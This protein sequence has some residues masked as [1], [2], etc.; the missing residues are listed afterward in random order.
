M[1]LL[2]KLKR[3]SHSYLTVLVILGLYS[4]IANADTGIKTAMVISK[5]VPESIVLEGRVEAINHASI[6]AQVTGNINALQVQAGDEVTVGQGLLTIDSAIADQSSASAQAQAQQAQ[7]QLDLAQAQFKRQANLYKQNFIS[8]AAYDQAA[9]E[10]KTTTANAKASLAQARAANYS[11]DF[12]T[13]TAP[14]N[15]VI[16]SLTANVGDLA[17]PGR[18]LATMYDPGAL[19]IKVMLPQ[20]YISHI[21]T[22]AQII[23]AESDQELPKILPYQLI[24]NIN[25]SQ[26]LELRIN[27]PTTVRLIPGSPVKIRL[28][29]DSSHNILLIPNQAVVDHGGIP[30]VYVQNQ[31]NSYGLRKV[32]TGTHL[33]SD[34]EILAGLF[35]G[36]KII[37]NPQALISGQPNE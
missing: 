18:A 3:R 23:W 29:L 2:N 21:S 14:F 8:K 10:L 5:T 30:N 28:E 4:G 20:S 22:N 24:P 1:K 26:N 7:A 32:K 12:Y 35:A 33:A 16:S 17:T 11:N 31:D 19:R 9:A 37:R 27:L 25:S 6:A 15:G 34:I 13:I 36:E